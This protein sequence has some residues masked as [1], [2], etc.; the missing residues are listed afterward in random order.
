MGSSDLLVEVDNGLDWRA[1]RRTGLRLRSSAA[2][3]KKRP[4]PDG[5]ENGSKSIQSRSSTFGSAS[6]FGSL[7]LNI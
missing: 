7:A 3:R 5:V 2:M 4:F 6:S 1:C